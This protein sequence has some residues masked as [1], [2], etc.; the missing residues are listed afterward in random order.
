MDQETQIR[1]VR[2]VLAHVETRTTDRE[3]TETTREVSA[4]LDQGRFAR[5]MDRL[6]RGLPVMIAHS[7]EL[8]SPGSFVTH[9]A[10]GIPLL[11]VRGDDGVLRAHRGASPEYARCAWS[12]PASYRF[13]RRP[14]PAPA[15]PASPPPRAAPD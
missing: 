11:V 15:R 10:L 3:E 9:D 8:A 6:F 13:R 1:L 14:A 2:R 7:S 12:A 4:Y 5:E